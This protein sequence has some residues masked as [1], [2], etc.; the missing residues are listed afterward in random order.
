MDEFKL[1]RELSAVNRLRMD[2][3]CYRRLG[4]WRGKNWMA[5]PAGDEDIDGGNTPRPDHKSLKDENHSA[6]FA[7]VRPKLDG[8][9]SAGYEHRPAVQIIRFWK[10]TVTA[11]IS[12]VC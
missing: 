10:K 2:G 5:S 1:L 7:I 3:G 6:R 4:V 8:L 11:G 12:R 9:K